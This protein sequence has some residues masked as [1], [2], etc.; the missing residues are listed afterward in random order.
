MA[1]NKITVNSLL[2]NPWAA[3]AYCVM[4]NA[5]P[6]VM[7]RMRRD[8]ELADLISR[9]SDSAFD[10][11]GTMIESGTS[12]DVAREICMHDLSETMESVR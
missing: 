3:H 8:G 4:K 7:R 1:T 12:A 9:E 5:R 10:R 2:T 6:G 11:F